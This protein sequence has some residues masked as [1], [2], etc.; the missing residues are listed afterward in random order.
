[1]STDRAPASFDLDGAWRLDHRVAIRPERFGALLYHFGTRRLSVLKSPTLVTVVSG[2]AGH[3]TA[4]A[5][6]EQAGSARRLC[7]R[8]RAALSA[9]AQSRMIRARAAGAL[10][11]ILTLDRSFSHGRDWGSPHIPEK[12]TLRELLRF[13]PEGVTHPRWLL[14]YAR[15]GRLPD[16]SVP[17]VAEPSG[18]VPTFFGAYGQWMETAPPSWEDVRWLRSQWDGPFL[19]KGA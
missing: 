4:R 3:P 16:L 5:A 13:T 10:G 7:P 8:Y 19:V 15:T 18:P 6:C 11:I 2:L 12:L 14:G 17:K 9:L 1:V